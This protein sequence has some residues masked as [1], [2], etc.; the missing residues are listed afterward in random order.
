LTQIDKI[1]SLVFAEPFFKKQDL[2]DYRNQK[3]LNTN[4][5][6]NGLRPLS[7]VKKSYPFFI[8]KNFNLLPDISYR[9]LPYLDY[10]NIKEV[11]SD[12]KLKL[13]KK[14]K[15][16]LIDNQLFKVFNFSN[17]KQIYALNGSF[18]PAFLT[19]VE[20]IYKRKPLD[21]AIDL[22]ETDNPQEQVYAVFERV[23]YLLESGK[24]INH[25]KI[26]NADEDDY[27]QLSKLFLDAGISAYQTKQRSIK[28]HPLYK[29][30]KEYFL[31][32]PLE[33]TK[34]YL[35][36]LSKNHSSLIYPL[37][38]CFN[39]Y[40]DKDIESFK[41]VFIYEM[42][43]LTLKEKRPLN[44]IDF[45][46]LDQ[47]YNK[48]ETYL[49]MNY[50]DES[51]PKK[52]IDNDFLSNHQKSMINY[53]TSEH[54]NQYRK[55]I[56]S[57]L[58]DEL[59]II[60]F[61]P[62][63][64][65]TEM[66]PSSLTMKRLL[67]VHQYKYRVKE[68]SYLKN[69]DFLRYASLKELAENYHI[70]KDDYPRLK[71]HYSDYKAFSHQFKGIYND[72]L[73]DLL[74]RKYTLTG[75]KIEMLNLCPFQYFLTNLLNFDEFRDNHYIYFGNMLHKALESVIK[76]PTFDYEAMV[77][78]SEDFPEDILYKKDIFNEIL[79][80][81]IDYM[82]DLV[83]SFHHDSNYKKIMTE[84][85]FSKKRKDQDRFLMTG[86]IDK[87]M[88]NEKTNHY[89][90]I[91]YKY[92]RHDFSLDD[93]KKGRKLQLPFY[94]LI[95]DEAF[96]LN[97]SGIFYRQTGL[98]RMKK[99]DDSDYRLN[100]VFID[101][102][103]EMKALDPDGLNIKS[104]R[105][106]KTGMFNYKSKISKSEFEDMKTLMNHIVDQAAKQI[107]AGN[108]QIKPIL[109]EEVGKTSISCVYCP[110]ASICYS[111]NKRLEEVEADEVHAITE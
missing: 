17:Y 39:T 10:I 31:S 14:I 50:T 68:K 41:D 25:I 92:S 13:C 44:V 73:N 99:I 24:N 90:I 91:D 61:Y 109:N 79:L 89:I 83:Q 102:L 49:I 40:L 56:M 28:S 66:R 32:H 104:L 57:F 26:V 111:K 33:E 74:N 2:L 94:Y 55:N 18:V 29:K 75:K 78:M 82:I 108:F 87:V 11:Y 42:D 72:D 105:Y 6:I 97:V 58:F 15:K 23:V 60:L 43:R 67:Q 110:H 36:D 70:I 77:L 53:P 96:D 22:Y 3:I 101:D 98:N 63:E 1:S 9:I 100:G 93:M 19:N 95:F 20:T 48:E 4:T 59:D 81:N 34:K 45:I 27:Y 65:V 103:D 64:T 51:I 21:K 107:E 85:P 54:I 84:W 16:S 71:S 12:E 8:Y 37:I 106:T 5:Y 30:V 7:K 46:D 38:Q 69:D 62:K 52:D 80:E 86:I 47:V 35:E 88:I 76:D